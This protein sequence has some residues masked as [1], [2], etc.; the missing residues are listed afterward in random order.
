MKW[1]AFAH[2]ARRSKF[3]YA[4]GEVSPSVSGPLPAS[5]QLLGDMFGDGLLTFS[6]TPDEAEA[7]AGKLAD[8]AAAARAM[9][10]EERVYDL[11]KTKAQVEGRPEPKAGGR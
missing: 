1:E 6:L 10:V 3:R 9:P 2:A 7:L 5:V 8:A 4:D 11:G